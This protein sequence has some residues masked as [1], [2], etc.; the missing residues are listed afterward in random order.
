MK[1]SFN[2]FLS[3]ALILGFAV[4]ISLFASFNQSVQHIYQEVTIN[5]AHP[6]QDEDVPAQESSFTIISSAAIIPFFQLAT[7]YLSFF[8]FEI[9]S[10]KD[11][12][13]VQDSS[14]PNYI[15]IYFKTLFSRII[16]PNAP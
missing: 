7:A 11:K 2:I 9:S 13:L 3:R 6:A 10:N 14:V 4:F 16:S 1:K 5:A 15:N 12:I 8:I